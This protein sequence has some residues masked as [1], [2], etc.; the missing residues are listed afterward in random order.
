MD[1]SHTILR[2]QWP[3]IASAALLA[4]GCG[5]TTTTPIPPATDSAVTL[6]QALTGADA[7]QPAPDLP[8]TA[9]AGLPTMDKAAP[10]VTQTATFALG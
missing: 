10:T 2:P 8:P 5:S 7:G 6:D 9:S 3:L 4:W 1:F